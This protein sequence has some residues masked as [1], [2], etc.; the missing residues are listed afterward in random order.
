LNSK[1]S[2]IKQQTIAG[3]SW[4]LLAQAAAQFSSFVIT[5]ILSRLL[6]PADFGLLGMVAVFTGFAMLISKAGLGQALIQKQEQDL[7]DDHYSSAFWLNVGIGVVMTLVLCLISPFIA[8]FYDEPRLQPIIIVT[9]LVFLIAPANIIQRT[10]LQKDMNFRR[11][12]VI[13]IISTVSAGTFGVGLALS[14]FG[15]WSLVAIPLLETLFS[16]ALMWIKTDWKPERRFRLG[17]IGE[18]SSY[19]ANYTGYT[20]VDYLARNADNLLVGRFLGAVA[21]GIY[22]RAY[23]LMFLPISQIFVVVSQVMYPAFAKIQEDHARV[24]SV[25]EK[26]VSMTVLMSAPMM[27]GLYAVAEPFILAI[28]GPKWADVV[29]I[30]ESLAIVGFIRSVTI[31]GQWIFQ[32]QGRVDIM[33]RWEIIR[34][35]L[36]LLGFFISVYLQ[37]LTVLG[38]I[39]L[40]VTLILLPID[41]YLPTRIIGLRLTQ[42]ITSVLGITIC[43]AIMA[44]LVKV[45]DTFILNG[46]NVWMRLISG[47]VVGALVYVAT[48]H[49]FGFESYHELRSM[50]LEQLKPRIPG[51]RRL[52]NKSGV[53]IGAK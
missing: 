46:W 21:L 12:A 26:S 16:V 9:S 27:L 36:F 11:L 4:T 53:N 43:A 5:A 31:T 13:R 42:L 15:V 18:L 17:A 44:A 10:I 22:A 6:A 50:L 49:L 28:Y 7:H 3:I 41:L 38:Q 2:S 47:V 35:P 32:S 37:D 48:V 33:F 1:A 30:L 14:G 39:Y 23:S 51:T 45:T 40:I 20:V 24:R 34:T 8:H 29:P 19:A 25:Y 52:K